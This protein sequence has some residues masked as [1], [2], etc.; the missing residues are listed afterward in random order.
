MSAPC[1]SGAPPRLNVIGPGR[2]GRTLTRLWN[3]AGLVSV[4]GLYSRNPNTTANARAF[5]G[6]GDVCAS[7]G[8]L[9]PAKL[10]LLA[11]PDAAIADT[12]R[13]LARAS[14]D[15]RDCIVSHCSGLH[16]SQLLMPLAVRGAVVASAHPLHSFADPLRSL[17]SFAGT[18]CA[19]EGDDL[20][21]TTLLTLFRKIGATTAVIQAEAKPLYHAAAAMASNYLVALLDSSGALLHSAGISPALATAMLEPLVRQ[22]ANN[23]FARDCE[24]ALTG[25]IARGDWNTV[26]E[27]LRAINQHLP[28]LLPLY[29]AL[30]T[31]TLAM[32]ERRGAMEASAREHL[33]QLLNEATEPQ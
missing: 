10:T 7:L 11:V 32:A 17:D 14:I 26:A 6:A 29:R 20:A 25:P 13:D 16:S 8:E 5:I 24:H 15:W 9:P 3:D 19:I 30:G 1:P 23:V 33:R 2:L 18:V 27:H 12:A 28:A 31:V 22:T 21:V 4:G